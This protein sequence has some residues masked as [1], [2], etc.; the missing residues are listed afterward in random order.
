MVNNKIKIVFLA[1]IFNLL[2]EYSIRGFY[3]L[4][5]HK[6]LIILLFILYFSYFMIVDS[7]IRKFRINNIQLLIVS[8]I[9][10]TLI[11]TFF[12]GNIFINPTFIGVNIPRFFFINII[13]WGFIQALLTF[14]LATR[15]VQRD[16]DEKPIGRL[17]FFM[18]SGFIIIFLIFTFIFI[19]T[20]KGPLTGYIFSLVLII[21]GLLYLK[22]K[23]QKPQQEIYI[24]KKSI[25]LDVLSFGSVIFFL[26]SGTFI[27]TSQ[28]SIDG[29]IINLLALKLSVVW[30]GLVFI[31]MILYYLKN[32]EQIST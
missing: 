12:A 7:L 15:L 3:G 23:L 24:F 5:L 25:Y 30:T 1:V 21:S 26:I 22:I 2:F 17:S 32:K 6:G 18:Y 29:M 9:F 27:A 13:W 14:Y 10:G 19:K 16:W 11:V 20:P 8:F 31:G 4:F 28:T